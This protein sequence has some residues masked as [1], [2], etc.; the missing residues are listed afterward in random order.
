M[1]VSARRFTKI[2]FGLFTVV[3]LGIQL[4]PYGRDHSNPAVTGEPPWNSPETRALFTRAC[5]DC[6]S[7]ETVWPWYSHIAPASWLVQDDVER[8]RAK[9]NLSQWGSNEHEADEAASEI[10]D[11]EMPLNIYT[12][13]HPSAAL[14]DAEKEK[15]AQGLEATLGPVKPGTDAGHADEDHE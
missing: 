2:F 7:N 3:L 15:L 9:M 8:G 6:H 1:K 5:A 10:R 11:G 4:V 12:L 14:T 13:M